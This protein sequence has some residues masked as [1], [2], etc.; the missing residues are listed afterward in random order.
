MEEKL[1]EGRGGE[2][3]VAMAA[4]SIRPQE[5]TTETMAEVFV[6]QGNIAKAV[7]IYQKLSLAYPHKSVYFASRI[8]QI[9][10]D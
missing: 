1:L 3:V 5:V 10:K 8:E 7:D 2:Q 6:K 9:K 4:G